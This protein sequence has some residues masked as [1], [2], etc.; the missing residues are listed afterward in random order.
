M[1]TKSIHTLA[2]LSLGKELAMA[3]LLLRLIIDAVDNRK[4]EN[5]ARFVFGKLPEEWRNPK[6]PAT[7]VEF[8]ELIQAGQTF[9][10]KIKAVTQ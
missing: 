9:I 6:G 8:I 3:L 10:R 2:K 1:L 4:V 5:V 7:E